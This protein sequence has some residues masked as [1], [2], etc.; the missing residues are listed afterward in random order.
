MIISINGPGGSGKSTLAK[1]LAQELGWPRYYIGGIR[2]KKAKAEGMTL[3]EYNKLG[4]SDPSTDIEVDKYQRRLCKKEDN[5]VIEGRTSWL[6]IP[7]S[8][9]IYLDVDKNIAAKRILADIKKRGGRNEDKN[10]KTIADVKESLRK[11]LESDKRRYKKYY[12]VDVYD[13]KHYDLIIDTSKLNQEEIF[14]QVISYIN[15]RG[16]YN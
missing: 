6:F 16:K 11:R 15:K 13:Q 5:F 1:M 12:N 2:R 8:I 7:H 14:N 4:E 3:A 10:L 9:K